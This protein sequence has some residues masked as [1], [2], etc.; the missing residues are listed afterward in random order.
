MQRFSR[1]LRPA[2]TRGNRQSCPARLLDIK[3]ETIT[4]SVTLLSADVTQ[5]SQKDQLTARSKGLF[6]VTD[7]DQK[8]PFAVEL[9][10]LTAGEIETIS[11]AADT[12]AKHFGI[13]KQRERNASDGKTGDYIFMVRVKNSA[14]GELT[15][16]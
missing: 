3:R 9:D 1:S 12:I 10:A 13:Y 8:K 6:Y 15:T 11:G 7:G 16:Q 2:V 14:G 5:M 4:I